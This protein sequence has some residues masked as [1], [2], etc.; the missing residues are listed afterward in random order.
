MILYPLLYRTGETLASHDAYRKV[1]SFC[2]VE[3]I[4]CLDLE[5]TFLP[6]DVDRLRAH[7]RNS[8]PSPE[9]NEI[10][11]AEILRFARSE[12]LIAE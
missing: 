9:A 6:L 10:A 7:P 1:A 12:A 2:R 11:A 3:R 4:R 8:H 5:P